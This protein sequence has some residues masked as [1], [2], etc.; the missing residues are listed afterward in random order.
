[1]GTQNERDLAGRITGSRKRQL[2]GCSLKGERILA[3]DK[4]L[5]RKFKNR[6]RN[7]VIPG[8]VRNSLLIFMQS[9]EF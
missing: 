4:D 7:E 6:G 1:M 8:R 3:D 5:A 2:W 9:C